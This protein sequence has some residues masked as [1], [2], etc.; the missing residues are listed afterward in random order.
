MTA[1]TTWFENS[2]ILVHTFNQGGL[3]DVKLVVTDSRGKVSTNTDLQFV[4][5]TQFTNPSAA[6]LL[7]I[8]SRLKIQT[9]DNILIG[10]FIVDGS[11]PKMIGLRA[12]GPSI[13]IPGALQ[14]PTLELH[15]GSGALVA[16]NDNWV[17]A[18]ERAQI[19]A[20]GLNPKDSRE[21][22]ILRT[23]DPGAYTAV[24]RGK[25]NGTGIGLVEAHDLNETNNS[26]LANLGSRGFVQTGDNVMI[27]GFITGNRLG[28]VSVLVRAIGPS[29]AGRVPNALGDPILELHDANGATAA[30]NDNWQDTQEAEIQQ[31]GAAP[32]DPHESAIIA[33]LQVGSHT[34]IVRG[35]NN[36]VGNAV[37]EVYNLP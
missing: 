36:G 22:A 3:Y 11:D 30:M 17:D 15:D 26:K 13:Q 23:L 2:S 20:V 21:P 8:S 34:A 18:P 33:S 19:E 10:G 9:G 24:V 5:V 37:V 6:Q 12:T 28:N 7:N 16:S 31:T 35:V 4:E 29:L 27:A 14:D 32:T 25:N 1:R